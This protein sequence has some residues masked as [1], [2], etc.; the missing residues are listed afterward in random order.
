MRRTAVVFV[1]C[2]FAAPAAFAQFV[3]V[4]DAPQ[5]DTLLVE[6]VNKPMQPTPARGSTMAQV[7]QRFGAPLE[8]MDARGGQKRQWPTINRWRYDNFIVYFERDRVIDV[9]AIQAA[10]VEIGPR[11]AI[12]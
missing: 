1:A 12:R 4:V 10:P 8:R 2:L 6:R 3:T 5:G 9:V 11:P 7:Q